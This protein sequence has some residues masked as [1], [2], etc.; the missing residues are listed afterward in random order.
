MKSGK[1]RKSEIKKARLERMKKR[2]TKVNPFK[3]PI[4][5]WAVPVNPAEIV[6]HSMYMDI[7]LFYVDKEFMCKLCGEYEI[8][9]VKRQKWW[10]EIAKGALETTAVLCRS[11]R[12]KKKAERNEQN[13]H[14]EAVAKMK[15]HPNEDF[16]KNT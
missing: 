1:Q 8:W 9:P 4:P 6:Y 7:P 15:P 3:G 10:Y 2:D 11:C 14:M 16:F 13:R 5:E 12:D